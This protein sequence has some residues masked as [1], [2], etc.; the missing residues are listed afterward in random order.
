MHDS[1]GSYSGPYWPQAAMRITSTRVLTRLPQ[2]CGT[3]M[4]QGAG[5]A[6]GPAGERR[7]AAA[8]MSRAARGKTQSQ[9]GQQ[10][11]PAAA[12]DLHAEHAHLQQ[13][14]PRGLAESGVAG[15]EPACGTPSVCPADPSAAQHAHIPA[16]PAPRPPPGHAPQSRRGGS[17]GAWC[18]RRARWQRWRPRGTRL[19]EGEGAGIVCFVLCCHCAD[20]CG[21]MRAGR[22]GRAPRSSHASSN[23]AAPPHS[24]PTPTPKKNCTTV[25]M[26][27][28]AL[29][30]EPVEAIMRIPT[31][32]GGRGS[33]WGCARIRCSRWEEGELMCA[34]RLACDKGCACAS[35]KRTVRAAR[36]PQP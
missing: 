6:A 24:P 23:A 1:L 12:T 27:K 36:Q 31:A 18:S 35:A 7:P 5:S 25:N 16:A 21:M 26:V 15:Q 22:G 8:C 29:S 19:R 33:V 20:A 10:C 4:T 14:K 3:E 11:K 2:P 13:Q 17:A 28:R 32:G 34:V 9:R 30:V